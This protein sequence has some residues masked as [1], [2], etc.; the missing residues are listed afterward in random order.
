MLC[1]SMKA[2]IPKSCL[3]TQ[4]MVLSV[5]SNSRATILCFWTGFWLILDLT[6]LITC[7]IW[8]TRGRPDILLSLT[9]P[10]SKNN[11]IVWYTKTLVTFNG[12]S[13]SKT[14]TLSIPHLSN[15]VL[16]V[17]PPLHC[18]GSK[19]TGMFWHVYSIH[20]NNQ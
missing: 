19:Q 5:I 3:K 8:I 4:L 12:F 20:V 16:F 9:H 11:L 15:T 7:S 17:C 1:L 10:I 2:P 14:W 6:A 13:N 18:N